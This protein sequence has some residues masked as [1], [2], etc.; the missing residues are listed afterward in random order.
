MPLKDD[1]QKELKNLAILNHLKHPNIV[2][3]LASYTHGSRH[4]LLFPLAETGNL[5]DLLGTERHAT[6]FESDETFLIALAGLS[7]GIKHVH[8]F[9]EDKIHLKLIGFHHDV[10]PR[11]ILVSKTD[12]ILADFGLSTFKQE[13]QESD[14]PF[15]AGMDDY[16]APE[17]EE[18]DNNFQAGIIHRSSDIWSLGGIIAEVA[19]YMALGSQAVK[20]FRDERQHRVRGFKLHSF[21]LGHNQSNPNVDRW[22]SMMETSATKACAMLVRLAR[23][24][25]SMAQSERPN[26]TEVNWQLQ[27]IALY[28]VATTVDDL[29]NQFRETTGSVDAA[30]EHMRFQAWMHATGILDSGKD[31]SWTAQLTYEIISAFKTILKC[32]TQLR[33]DLNSRIPQEQSGRHLSASRLKDINDQLHNF[34]S[35]DQQEIFRT[36]FNITIS[37]SDNELLQKLKGDDS[38]ISIDSE[39]RMR[40]TIKYMTTLATSS[41]PSQSNPRPVERSAVRLQDPPLG[42]H[43]LGWLE[44]DQVPQPVW[45]EW[46]NYTQHGADEVVIEKLYDRVAA[47]TQQLSQDK[48]DAF[49]TLTCCGFFHD[50]SRGAFGIIFDIPRPIGIF[51]P[52]TLHALIEATTD[53]R[54]LWPDLDDRFKLASTLASSLLELHTV[55]WLHKDLTSSNVVF[56]PEKHVPQCQIMR[57]PFLVGFNYSRPDDP[58]AFS[59]GPAASNY[60]QHPRYL[61]DPNLRYQ[62]EFDYYSLG[63]VLI[64]VGFWMPFHKVTKGYEGS[65]EDRRQAF[66][67]NRI[68]LLRQHMGREY[69]EAV[70]S[71][72]KSDFGRF[73]LGDENEVGSRTMLLRFEK[74]VVARLN[75]HFI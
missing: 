57:D 47:I 40:A 59:E 30:L 38:S 41:P 60:Y 67:K 14:T 36:Y 10:R 2:E 53:D 7:S 61:N 17:C 69:F 55:G 24:M 46:R 50:Q 35:R 29:F 70:I 71:C 18:W 75:K 25:L 56:F 48:P 15:K 9:V 51:E 3:L 63:I 52:Q 65:Y 43:R 4:N 37:E 6:E 54:K 44:G 33:E 68:S 28:Q 32:L 45:V 12:F 23:S 34:L 49:R 22:L 21:H 62:P 66:L 20:K 26:A 64:E 72:I 42:A 74:H 31:P 39:I 8:E 27:H 13:S 11:N 73:E 1:H 5:A 19:T 16:L 58:S